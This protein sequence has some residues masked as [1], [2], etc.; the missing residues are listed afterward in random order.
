VT[1]AATSVCSVCRKECKAG[2]L[3]GADS[4]PLLPIC[5]IQ[6]THASHPLAPFPLFRAGPLMASVKDVR[7]YH[8]AYVRFEALL[9]RPDVT[10]QWQHEFLLRPRDCI[11]FN[12]RRMLHGR[13]S[14]RSTVPPAGTRAGAGATGGGSAGGVAAASTVRRHLKG[15]YLCIDDF[16]SRYRVLRHAAGLS[17]RGL[18]DTTHVGNRSA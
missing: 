12:Q 9:H 6:H 4:L 18:D 14:F 11:T 15:T 3:H 17:L 8:E 13:R 1:H 2:G 10:R 16:L 5:R 7:R